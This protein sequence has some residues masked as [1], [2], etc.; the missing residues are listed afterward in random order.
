MYGTG[1]FT[2]AL[3]VHKLMNQ[4]MTPEQGKVLV[5]GATGGVGSLA[6]AILAREGFEVVAA[7][8]KD[9]E[10]F[11]LG[12][13]AAKVVGRDAVSGG[14][15]KAML[16]PRWAGVVDCVGGDILARAIKSTR[17]GGAVTS[18][19]NVAGADL[20]LTVYPFILRGISLLGIDAAECPLALRSKIWQQ[21]AS[22]WKFDH[23]EAQTSEVTWL[24]F[25]SRLIRFWPGR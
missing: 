24:A 15:D 17:P 19:G 10:D 16:R 12:L 18:C 1:G 22:A 2:A 6:V 25:Q 21:I 9:A 13:G 4:G 3:S 11:L 20:P 14:Q 23:L 7:S 8:G 5:T